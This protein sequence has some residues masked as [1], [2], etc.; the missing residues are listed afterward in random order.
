MKKRLKRKAKII[1]FITVCLVSV[2]T[3]FIMAFLGAFKDQTI[4]GSIF[5]LFGWYWLL[6][7]Q[8][9]MLY[10]IWRK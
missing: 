9:M 2:I 6:M 1:I 4:V 3:Y 10:V 8:I 5:V 7:G